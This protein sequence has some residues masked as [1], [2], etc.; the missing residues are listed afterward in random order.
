MCRQE[1]P[2]DFFSDPK[3]LRKEEV[4]EKSK[5]IFDEGFQWFYEGRNGWW[6][7]DERTSLELENKYKEGKRLFELL[8]AGFL[9]VIDLENMRQFRRNDQTRRRKIKR[10]MCNIPGIKGIAGI[11]YHGSQQARPNGDGGE[12][13]YSQVNLPANPTPASSQ[14]V[15]LPSVINDRGPVWGQD[16]SYPST[17]APNNTPQAPMTPADSQPGS[18]SS[19][20]E[21]LTQH[22]Q[23]MSL[24]SSD[25]TS[26]PWESQ[27]HDH[28]SHHVYDDDDDTNTDDESSDEDNEA[29]VDVRGDSQTTDGVRET[30][31]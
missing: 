11:K 9:Y 26:L 15:P 19:S 4:S 17:P 29:A 24:T 8:I 1:I 3:L 6:Q 14:S 28:H 31:L 22:L 20:H 25:V 7:Y 12:A 5:T 27:E 23:N 13:S 10:D 16:D 21:D 30:C 18:R 2:A